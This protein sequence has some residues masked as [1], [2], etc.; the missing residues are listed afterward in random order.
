MFYLFIFNIMLAMH[1]WPVSIAIIQNTFAS[2]AITLNYTLCW[3]SNFLLQKK[4][5]TK[6][7][8]PIEMGTQNKGDVDYDWLP[9][10]TLNELSK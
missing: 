4:R 7:R 5:L 1:I 6:P 2:T 8:Q 9:K 10:E 3:L